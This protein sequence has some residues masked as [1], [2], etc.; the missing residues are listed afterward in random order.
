MAHTLGQGGRRKFLGGPTLKSS[1][2]AETCS[3]CHSSTQNIWKLNFFWEKEK[4]HIFVAAF[5]A[6][7]E[8]LTENGIFL[9]EGG[10]VWVLENETLHRVESWCSET[11]KNKALWAWKPKEPRTENAAHTTA[12]AKALNHLKP[13][14]AWF[15]ADVAATSNPPFPLLLP[16]A[17]APSHLPLA[18]IHAPQAGTL[19]SYTCFHM[20]RRTQNKNKC[21]KKAKEKENCRKFAC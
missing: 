3:S 14:F 5:L 4:C 19:R 1:T 6:L 9:S 7:A 18:S 13:L 16:T 11:S 20:L 12:A 21:L 15:A 10:R 2:S 8:P 17:L